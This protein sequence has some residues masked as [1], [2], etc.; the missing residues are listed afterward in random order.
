VSDVPVDELV[1]TIADDP[2]P[3]RVDVTPSVLALIERGTPGGRAV[4]PLL[5]SPDGALRRH[6]QR[7]LEGILMRRHGWR[8]GRGFA[9]APGGE[10]EMQAELRSIGYE[11]DAPPTERRESAA[12]WRR[13]LDEQS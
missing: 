12:R 1:R 8:A 9:D 5:E 13:W 7:V 4:L 3:L 11:S 10:A 2:D 6:A